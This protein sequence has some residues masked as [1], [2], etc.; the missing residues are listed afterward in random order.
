MYPKFG[1]GHLWQEASKKIQA[2]GGTILYNTQASKITVKDNNITGVQTY[3]N[4]TQKTELL[5]ADYIFSTMPVKNLIQACGAA[6]PKEV[7]EIAQGLLYR[8]F[9]TVGI[10]VK[11]LALAE[12]QLLDNW[13]YIQEPDVLVGRIQIFNNWSPY[14]VADRSTIWLGL[15]YFCNEF[16]DLWNKNEQ[17]M[18]ELAKQELCA[19]GMVRH[20]DILDAT[21]I[22]IEKAYPA[23]FG[24]YDRF[25][26]IRHYL[27]T[28][29][30][31]F[32]IGRNG[33]HKYNNQ[34]HSMLTAMVAVDNIIAGLTDKTAIWSVN[35]EQEY[36]ESNHKQ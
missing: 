25:D 10:L 18:I 31:L 9:I 19:L 13:I 12:K 35:T 36:H 3:N 32:L 5:Q 8:D 33:M 17:E 26:I 15:E 2:W 30:N 16:D 4:V 7:Q 6:V 28:I 21:V 23:Y 11:N 24:T 20:E 14:M 27:D 34:D 1:P 22:K 29:E